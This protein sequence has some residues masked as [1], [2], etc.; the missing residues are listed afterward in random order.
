MAKLVVALREEIGDPGFFMGREAELDSFLNWAELS[1][2]QQAKSRAILSRRKKGKTALV[3][4]I[5]N[6]LYSNFDPQ[7][8]P[9][10]FRVKEDRMK[11]P[12]FAHLFYRSFMSQF[13]GF[14]LR[15][16][17]LVNKVPPLKR[18]KMYASQD[19]ELLEDI[20]D[21]EGILATDPALAWDHARDAPHRI[22]SIKDIRIIQIIDEFQFMNRYLYDEWGQ[23]NV[24]HSYMAAAES[25][26][27]PLIVTGSYIGW[28]D[29]ILTYMTSRFDKE[30][31]KGLTEFEALETVYNY[32]TRMNVPIRENTAAYIAQVAYNDPFYIS[33]I[34]RTRNPDLDLTTK[35]GVRAALQ[36][37]T[38]PD[39]GFIASVWLEYIE[40]AFSRVN[41]VN[42][43]KIVIY[44]A[45]YG[46]E[47]RSR[48][49]ILEDL[50]L[51]MSDGDLEK[52]LHKL[53]MADLIARGSS[54]FRYKGLGDPI[55][56]AVFRKVYGEEIEQVSVGAIAEDFEKSMI[57]LKQQTAW[58]KG[59]RA[60]YKVRFHL[61]MAASKGVAAEMVIYNPIPNLV[62]EPYNTMNKE[63][64]AAGAD[65][66]REVDIYARTI[67]ENGHDLIVE[68]KKWEKQ[69]N[70]AEI[71]AF[72]NLKAMAEKTVVKKTG[73]L[74]YSE[75]GFTDKQ[76]AV[77]K[78]AGVMYS[79]SQKLTSYESTLE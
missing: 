7:V 78:E 76:M 71:E 18:L 43:K 6:I 63:R 41:E 15:N 14:Q 20:E 50:E 69:V 67:S 9:F 23:A 24:C 48:K 21:M 1:K 47:D 29:A 60:E 27:A 58:M 22:A 12:D 66:S 61:F 31:L 33:Q 77:M 49:Q 28:L 52:R 25:K 54:Y 42:A 64:I 68:V 59:A 79:D 17:N 46:S 65:N 51:D 74:F 38:T 36:F 53:R 56:E 70:H 73:F 30:H 35:E 75:N 55:F 11:I 39:L 3:Q 13:L 8:V 19:P 34:I 44:L 40:D 57:R 37:E 62:L 16:P 2:L 4:R 72:L 10:F 45:K 26:V 5:F 32:A